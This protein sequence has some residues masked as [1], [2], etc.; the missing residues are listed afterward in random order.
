MSQIIKKR[1]IP[2]LLLVVLCFGMVPTA[3]AEAEITT[4]DTSTVTQTDVPVSYTHLDVYKRQ[5]YPSPKAP[6]FRKV[7]RRMRA[8]YPV[9][10]HWRTEAPH[11]VPIVQRMLSLI[12]IYRQLCPRVVGIGCF[13]HIAQIIAD[14]RNTE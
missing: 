5:A 8:A 13:L 9:P 4:I 14:A 2:I 6:A 7:W 3:F 12:H 1:I 11:P 10:V